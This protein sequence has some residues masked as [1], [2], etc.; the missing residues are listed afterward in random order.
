MKT[1]MTPAAS[2]DE[3]LNYG[4]ERTTCSRKLY[5]N[6]AYSQQFDYLDDS[7]WLIQHWF[8][9]FI[10][11]NIST[12]LCLYQRAIRSVVILHPKNAGV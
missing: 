8:S 2:L 7:L 10:F 3:R 9:L 12:N 6:L 11:S 4:V 1:K 5:S